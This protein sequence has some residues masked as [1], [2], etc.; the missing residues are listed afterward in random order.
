MIKCQVNYNPWYDELM[1]WNPYCM[2]WMSHVWYTRLCTTKT[3]YEISQVGFDHVL[4][5]L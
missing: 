3:S 2:A 4:S 5:H 1:I